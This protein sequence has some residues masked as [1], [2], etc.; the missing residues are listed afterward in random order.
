MKNK[1][2][3]LVLGIVLLLAGCTKE[4]NVPDFSQPIETT[5]SQENSEKMVN[6]W[7]EVTK[8]EFDQKTDKTL[9]L[10]DGIE[11][12]VYRVCESSESNTM[13]EVTFATGDGFSGT[14]Y[15]ARVMMTD[16]FE[17]ISGLYYEG[18]QEEQ[19]ELAG[20]DVTMK[21]LIRDDFM[22]HAVLW[23]DKCTG[24]SYSLAV[25][26][27]DLNGF[28]ITVMAEKMIRLTERTAA[29]KETLSGDP[30]VQAYRKALAAYR[31][32]NVLPDGTVIEYV[33]AQYAVKDINNDGIKEWI[34]YL[35]GGYVASMIGLIYQYDA[36]EEQWFCIHEGFPA[37]VFYDNGIMLE[38]W[39]HNQGP[40]E[41]WPYTAYKYNPESRKYEF[42]AKADS[43]N[44]EGH[45]VFYGA[46]YPE[47]TDTEGTG[48]VYT[49]ED[50][51]HNDMYEQY[52]GKAEYDAF[53]KQM[54]DDA[55]MIPVAYDPNLFAV[56]DQ[57]INDVLNGDF[58]AFAG[59]YKATADSSNCYGGGEPLA[60]LV[61][62]GDGRL[63]GGSIDFYSGSDKSKKPMQITRNE[64]GSFLCVI[65]ELDDQIDSDVD[66]GVENKFYIYPSGIAEERFRNDPQMVNSVYIRFVQI[67]GGVME[68]VYCK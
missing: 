63:S 28:D 16:D 52:I 14:D 67:D 26:K 32:T 66:Y 21:A 49:I 8:E 56:D 47:E 31:E 55:K 5:E 64:D 23:Y 54:T 42:Y 68:L 57:T 41:M 44:K 10:P 24:C 33:N 43:W 46:A 38:E 12:V 6:P 34:L 4:Q 37:F 3:L 17:D 45:E 59:T 11:D 40:G 19:G 1:K 22:I 48:V 65:S 25:K 62:Y 15:T 9:S 61:L 2:R 36:S 7:S 30:E 20:T 53:W 58:S 18:W 35:D 13:G 39:S 60:D 27:A 51:T 29:E 50:K